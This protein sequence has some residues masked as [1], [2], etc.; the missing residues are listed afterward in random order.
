MAKCWD[1]KVYLGRRCLLRNRREASDFL[2]TKTQKVVHFLCQGGETCEREKKSEISMLVAINEHWIVTRPIRTTFQ[3]VL[4]EERWC[5]LRNLEFHIYFYRPSG[6]KE[7]RNWKNRLRDSALLLWWCLSCV[8]SHSV[9]ER[10]SS[11]VWSC[12]LGLCSQGFFSKSPYFRGLLLAG[13]L[14]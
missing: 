12:V 4:L 11:H 3:S 14:V 2:E 8:P 7:R 10:N 9:A 13:H 1:T 6:S 5:S